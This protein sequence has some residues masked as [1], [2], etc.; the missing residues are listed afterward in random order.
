[1]DKHAKSPK[2]RGRRRTT[3]AGRKQSKAGEER[4]ER[5][6]TKKDEKE[7]R[8]TMK[9]KKEQM[10]TKKGKRTERKKNGKGQRGMN[11]NK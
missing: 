9:N 8:L 6:R 3:F 11:S 5:K 1:M 7:Q 10:G 4:K 2:M